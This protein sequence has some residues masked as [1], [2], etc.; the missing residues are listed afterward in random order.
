MT[1]HDLLP[2]VRIL[3]TPGL[4]DTRGTQQD[5]L[6]NDIIAAQIKEY[7]N[8]VTVI[9]VLANGTVPGVTVGT[10]HALA[11]LSSKT[12]ANNIGV[13]LTNVSNPLYSN[14]ARNV[15]PVVLKDAPQFIVNN[16]IALQKKYLTLKDDPNMKK[17]NTELRKAVKA[18]ERSALEML[19][20]LF[21]WLESR[22][23]SGN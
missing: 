12:S 3:D 22:R 17:T 16:P 6:H 13:V 19:V 14:F 2:K 5:E 23:S 1:R 15:I 20:D 10:T 7:I 8:S 11:T 4:A 18:G 21:G 9:L